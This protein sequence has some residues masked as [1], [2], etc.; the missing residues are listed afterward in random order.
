[1][2]NDHDIPYWRGVA[3]IFLFFLAICVSVLVLA[4]CFGFSKEIWYLIRLI[5]GVEWST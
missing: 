1:M 4:A 2:S 5:I 3:Y